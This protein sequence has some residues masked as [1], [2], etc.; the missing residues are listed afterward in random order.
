MCNENLTLPGCQELFRNYIGTLPGKNE[1]S[2]D[3]GRTKFWSIGGRGHA[4]V[5]AIKMAV[6]I[7]ISPAMQLAMTICLC[8]HKN[9]AWLLLDS[10]LGFVLAPIVCT[11]ATLRL[12]AGAIFHPA[13]V[14]D[15]TRNA[16][17]DHTWC[18]PE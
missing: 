4:V 1:K 14:Y 6:Y 3:N 9:V 16:Y 2:E 13:L 7:I 17:P 10:L 11:A 5:A 8:G 15:P 12:L 18:F